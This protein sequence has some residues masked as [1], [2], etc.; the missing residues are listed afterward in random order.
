M[1]SAKA[2]QLDLKQFVTDE[3]GLP[4]LTDIIDEIKR[5]GRD[6]REQF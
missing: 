2:N 3:I 6:P 5:P 4:T 1:A